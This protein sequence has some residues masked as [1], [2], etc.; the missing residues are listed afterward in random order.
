MELIDTHC[1][2]Q[3]IGSDTVGVA[4]KWANAGIESVSAV[5]GAAANAGVSTLVCV[6]CSLE[7]SS[8]AVSISAQYES[9]W[10][11]IG[12]HPHEAGDFLRHSQQSEFTELLGTEPRSRKIIA[13]GECGLDHHYNNSEKSD[14]VAVLEFQLKLATDLDLPVI[15]HVREAFD[16]FW[17]IL[18]NFPG[19]SGVLHSFTDSLDNMERALKAGFYLGVNGIA[20][21]N[22]DEE[23]LSMYKSIPLSK[24]LLETDSP[25]LTPN[26]IRGKINTPENVT[27][28]TKYMA[29]LN[30]LS[31]EQVAEATTANARNLFRI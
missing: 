24:L 23:L 31:P 21:F 2:I 27:Y 19:I 26:P 22:R 12:I 15:F 13:I 6:G 8:R 18:R 3:D 14:Q 17:P 11:S 28:I 16:E 29:E 9:L 7:D 5:I 20:T 1:H 4:S 10:A 30:N 25:Y